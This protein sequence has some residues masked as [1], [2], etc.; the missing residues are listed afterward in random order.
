VT[1]GY[2]AVVLLKMTLARADVLGSC[3]RHSAAAFP[4][5]ARRG[6][7]GKARSLSG[8]RLHEEIP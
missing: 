3:R 1:I 8:V 7:M 2:F 5:G 6:R 4:E